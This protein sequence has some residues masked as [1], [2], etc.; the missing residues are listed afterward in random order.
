MKR[1]LIATGFCAGIFFL[2]AVSLSA[3]PARAD[4]AFGISPPFMHA[5][6]L[7]P[8][9]RYV[10]TVY[11][12]QDQPDQDLKIKAELEITDKV[13][14]WVTID[15][16]FE[17]V[18][19]QGTRQY[20]VQVVVQ[21][22]E[23]ADRGS[24]RG[25]V[26][27]TT[28]PAASGQ[29]TIALGAQ[30][31][32]D[33]VVGD[34]IFRQFSVPVIRILDIEEGWDPKVYVKFNNEGNVEEVFDGATFELYDQFNAVR[35]AF[36]QKS[37]DFPGTPPFTVEE[38]TLDFPTDFHLGIGQYWGTVNFFQNEK[39]VASQKTVFNVLKRGSIAGPGAQLIASLKN[40]WAY[41]AGGVLLLG[42][43]FLV[44]RKRLGRRFS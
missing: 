26:T 42:G 11:L 31:S 38:Y 39:V 5:T 33:I 20:P 24:Y 12:V 37:K 4:A 13:R 25:R 35:L 29:V 9:S 40:N 8:G 27:F 14:S 28:A 16:G 18:I 15:R 7:V 1:K 41:W 6:H 21:A 3:L 44:L 30:V 36:V 23:G 19:P 2:F 43:G 32:I 22:P 34:D 10:Q 17:F